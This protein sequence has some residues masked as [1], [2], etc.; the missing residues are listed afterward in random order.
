MLQNS[1][2]VFV[3]LFWSVGTL[4][5]INIYNGTIGYVFNDM[6]TLKIMM[7]NVMSLFQNFITMTNFPLFS[8]FQPL[9]S[10][11]A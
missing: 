10:F 3:P 11:D 5:V 4:M 8:L 9:T 6:E 2:E 7:L 1:D